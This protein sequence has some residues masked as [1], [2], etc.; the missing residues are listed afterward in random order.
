MWAYSQKSTYSVSTQNPISFVQ[1]QYCHVRAQWPRTNR[2]KICNT[3][4][5]YWQVLGGSSDVNVCC[6]NSHTTVCLPIDEC[7]WARHPR[8]TCD[9]P[10]NKTVGKHV[11]ET[12]NYV[13]KIREFSKTDFESNNDDNKTQKIKIIQAPILTRWWTVGVGSI[14]FINIFWSFFECVRLLL[15]ERIKKTQRIQ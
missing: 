5:L 6:Y 11:Q 12:W 9:S 2:S 8:S 4:A 3:K 10:C 13:K 1:V 15:T 14:L 7:Q